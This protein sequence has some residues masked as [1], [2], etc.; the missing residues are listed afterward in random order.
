MKRVRDTRAQ[1]NKRWDDEHGFVV[2]RKTRNRMN[3]KLRE[4]L[5]GQ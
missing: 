3:R 2:S 1:A 4:D 5:A